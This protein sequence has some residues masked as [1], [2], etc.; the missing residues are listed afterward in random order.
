MLD[1]F[2]LADLRSAL[3]QQVGLKPQS[4]A[5]SY[6]WSLWDSGSNAAVFRLELFG[7]ADPAEIDL[8]RH[9]IASQ[10]DW[11]TVYGQACFESFDSHLMERIPAN[12]RWDIAFQATYALCARWRQDYS[13][14]ARWAFEQSHHPRSGMPRHLRHQ[15]AE[16]QLHA[17]NEAGVLALVEGDTSG[18]AD[19]LRA[20]L[21]VQRGQW[22]DAALAFETALKKRQQEVGA[23]KRVFFASL[24][25]YYPLAL[26]AQQTP[27]AVEAARKFCL[28]ES[29]K[30]A[31]R[32]DEGWGLWVHAASIR[33]GDVAPQ[34]DSF[35]MHGGL[36]AYVSMETLWRLLLRTWMLTEVPLPSDKQRQSKVLAELLPALRAR[37]NG[38]DL[39]WIVQQIDIA[40]AMLTNA[41]CG[42]STD[43]AA[44]PVAFFAASGTEAWR[45]VLASL[46]A[47]GDAGDVGAGKSHGTETQLWWLLTLGKQGNVVD[48]KP[49]ER[50]RPATPCCGPSCHPRGT[51]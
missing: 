29:G 43:A 51:A 13:P 24:A 22:V 3:H 32:P 10:V 42:T 40:E 19:A 41:P 33:L 25:W 2:S 28:G 30:K 26:L 34:P 44:R 23:K 16:W 35:E 21:M 7:G 17:G 15:L 48:I 31:P 50:K 14:I 18:Q 47:L 39:H 4:D 5:Y 11:S 37:L 46:Q 6:H 36:A 27:R 20:A 49:L 9:R 38:C 8:L 1:Q 12:W 45:G